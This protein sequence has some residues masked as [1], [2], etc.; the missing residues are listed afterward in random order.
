[1]K[2]Y[3]IRV[4]H[5]YQFYVSVDAEDQRE[6]RFEAIKHLVFKVVNDFVPFDISAGDEVYP[7]DQ[8]V[9]F[10]P[11]TD[12]TLVGEKL[13]CEQCEAYERGDVPETW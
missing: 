9:G 7:C 1:M 3:Y 8:C 10:Y 6:A 5:D 4:P 13:L 2:R 11:K 12:L